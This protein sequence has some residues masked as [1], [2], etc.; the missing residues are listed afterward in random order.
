MS[1]IA[2]HFDPE[3]LEPVIRQV[4]EETLVRLES[5]RARLD[6]KLA[7]SEE[8]AARLLGLAVHV[9]RDE[10]LRGRITASQ[11]VGKRI[12]YMREDLIA[13]LLGRRWQKKD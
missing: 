11:I 6:G 3:S 7:Y 8:E 4:V 5:E 13:Y 1:Q 12:R 10:R 9:L 2:L